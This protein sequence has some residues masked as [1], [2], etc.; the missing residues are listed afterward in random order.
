MALKKI[1]SGSLSIITSGDPR[2][3]GRKICFPFSEYIKGHLTVQNKTN[4]SGRQ[5]LQCNS[6]LTWNCEVIEG[7]WAEVTVFITSM[8]LS[9]AE[10]DSL[11]FHSCITIFSCPHDSCQANYE[12]VDVA[13][14]WIRSMQKTGM[15]FSCTWNFEFCSVDIVVL[16]VCSK[17]L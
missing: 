11:M 3:C 8:S 12:L 13:T 7:F 14:A 4:W 15:V 10:S 1:V 17:S 2:I 16:C 5:L 9:K 6:F